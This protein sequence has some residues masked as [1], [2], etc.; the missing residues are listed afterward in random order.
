[1]GLNYVIPLIGTTGP[2]GSSG[3]VTG[4]TGATGS[5]GVQGNAGAAGAAGPRGANGVGID[6]A[7]GSTGPAGSPGGATGPTGVAGATGATGATGVGASGAT[8]AQGS[9]GPTG[10]TGVGVTGPTGPAGSP[11]GATG[12]TGP[13]GATGAVGVT[14]ATGAGATGATGAAGATGPV[15][16]GG[17]TQITGTEFTITNPTGPVVNIV[18]NNINPNTAA[19]GAGVSIPTGFKAAIGGT[20]GD[21]DVT[22]S[23][24]GTTKGNARLITGNTV[25]DIGT[26]SNGNTW[27][28]SRDFSDFTVHYDLEFNPLGGNV[29]LGGTTGETF[30]QTLGS[31]A[32]TI[33]RT[34]RNRIDDQ[35][36]VRDYGALGDGTTNDRTAIAAADAAATAAGAVLIF[37]AGTY[38]I[39]TSLTLTSCCV[40]MGGMLTIP[41]AQTVSFTLAA[42]GPMKK[43]FFGSGVV[44]MN[45]PGAQCPVEWWG[46]GLG[47]SDSPAIQAA[48][49]ACRYVGGAGTATIV[50]SGN[51]FLG[52]ALSVASVCGIFTASADATFTAYDGNTSGIGFT[53]F[54]DANRTFYL[55]N[56]TGFTTYALLV[57]CNVGRFYIGLINGIN[58]TGDGIRLGTNTLNTAVLD[59][60]FHVNFIANCKSG[61]RIFS[62]TNSESG[63]IATIEG[64][65]FNVNFINQCSNGV[66][67]D[68]LDDYTLPASA[69][70]IGC[71]W[72]CNI[73]NITA[74]DAGPGVRRGFWYRATGKQY[75]M[76]VFRVPAWFGGF[77]SSGIWIDSSASTKSTFEIGVRTGEQMSSYGAFNL[78]GSGN[79]VT[80]NG[81]GNA[82]GD[83]LTMDIFNATTSAASRASFNGG[84]PIPRNRIRINAQLGSNLAIGGVVSF[85]AY[86]PI[87]DGY[88]NRLRIEF[89]NSNGVMVD[90]LVDNSNT[91]ASEIV[92]TFRNVSGAIIASGVVIEMWLE[93]AY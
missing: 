60:I 40:F 48:I 35:F 78:R 21:P 31:R 92:M 90:G 8:G 7:T 22:G 54:W 86:S 42:Q 29:R 19:M 75:S 63:S 52:A 89:L 50:L 15:G 85:Y 51:Y 36:N 27:W 43:L 25:C 87:I 44:R 62:N 13:T 49:E 74:L 83:Q 2:T 33:L 88:S 73:F 56:F 93:I 6:G 37:P 20:Q 11:G 41:A 80:I 4:A 23:G 16:A 55:P 18:T 26:R 61:I 39:S 69:Y 70:T 10:A 1:M 76:N 24:T 53:G 12:V 32:G 38:L 57:Q 77:D 47:A 30:G 82:F 72:D 9:T 45:Y 14:G 66:V 34:F 17:I 64:N 68:S 46:T 91:N 3:G 5:Q 79:V 28:Q 81:S 84:T 71:A 58:R 67:F 65:E 59:N